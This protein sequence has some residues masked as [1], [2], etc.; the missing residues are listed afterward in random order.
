MPINP[1]IILQQQSVAD[2]RRQSQQITNTIRLSRQGGWLT[3]SSIPQAGDLASQVQT[4]QAQTQ[5]FQARADQ[6]NRDL[7][8]QNT[9]Q[10]ALKDPT[11]HF[12]EA[13]HRGFLA[14]RK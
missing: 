5:E 8:D 1:S 14:D 2:Q 3:M 6:R 12:R 10:E 7:A 4:P 13:A 9:I 11:I